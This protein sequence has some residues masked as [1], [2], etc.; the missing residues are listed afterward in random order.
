MN[1]LYTSSLRVYIAL[2]LLALLGIVAGLDLPISLYP[3][4]NRPTIQASIPYG[5]LNSTEFRETYGDII[6]QELK[7]IETPDLAVDKIVADYKQNTLYLKIEFGW[8]AEP[9]SAL[10]EVS[11]TLNS[12]SGSWPKIVRDGLWVDYWS[13]SGGF[14]AVSFYSNKRTLDELYDIL[15][16]ELSPKLIKVKDASEAGLWNPNQKM[17]QVELKPGAMASLGIFPRDVENAIYKGFEGYVGGSITLGPKHINIQMS[18]QVDN[19]EDLKS[20]LVQT[21]SG[22]AVT[23]DEVASLSIGPS[24]KSTR[25]F[26]TSGAKSLI[27]FANPRSGGNVKRMAEEVLE[28]VESSKKDFPPDIQYKV[29]VDPSEFIR[30]A[31][32][33]VFHEVLMAAG[34]AVLVL[35]LFIGSLKNT[36]TAAIEI[37][38][39]MVLAFILMKLTDMNINL[40]S[41][42]GLALSAGMNVDAS[43]VVMENIF[44]HL[45]EHEG[46][47]TY[48]DKVALIIRA[49][50]EVSLPIMGAT[51][52]SLVVFAPLAFTS[53]LTNAILGDLAKAVVF[54]HGFSAVVAIILVPTVRLHMMT[55]EKK[56]FIPTSP[57]EGTLKKMERLYERS[58]RNFLSR[59][60]LQYTV[61][62]LSVCALIGALTFIAPN[63]KREIIGTPDTDW[64]ILGVN[65]DGQTLIAQ[66]EAVT[67]RVEADLLQKF[68]ADIG[69][70]FTQIHNPNSSNIMGRLHNKKDMDRI[71]KAMQEH[72]QNTPELRFWVI[73]WN[74]AELPIPNPPD[75]TLEVRGGNDEDRALVA[76]SLEEE[77]SKLEYF[78]SLWS[79]PSATLDDIIAIRP[80]TDQWTQITKSG[81]HFVPYDLADL[82]RVA[83]EGKTLTNVTIAGDTMNVN[84][85]YPAGSLETREDIEALPVQV[86]GKLIPLGALA[87]V[88]NEKATPKVSRED[89]RELYKVIGR[90]NKGNESKAGPALEKTDAFLAKFK[91]EMK[92]KLELTSAPAVA[93]VDARKELSDALSQLATAIGLSILLIF[94]TLFFQ[95]GHL[96]HVAIVLTAIPSGILGVLI[97]LGV[98][99]STLSLNSALGIILL[100]GIAVA[101][102]IIMVDF[103]RVM[104]AKGHA[105][106]EAAIWASVKRLRPI[107][108]TSL[109]TILGMLP[110]ALGLGEGGKVLRPLGLSVAGGLWVSMLFTLYIVPALEYSF[111]KKFPPKRLTSP[112]GDEQSST[113]LASQTQEQLQ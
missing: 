35:F 47:L 61:Y 28:I 77:L 45:E 50:K 30:D 89:G 59:P 63:L 20:V 101:N 90:F 4:S 91:E 108:I 97:A 23:L 69:Y 96:I 44:R 54:S 10:R 82:S 111:Y 62:A 81:A 64:V 102:S 87:Q 12:L 6:E 7:S 57:I 3:N 84:M 83:T 72:F 56:I 98:F 93:R 13:E 76:K 75:M 26:K 43:V 14:I 106:K 99:Q 17:L 65:T 52:A 32:S 51:I 109:T 18:R 68:G 11:T 40:I 67:D 85:T 95:F 46:E 15:E 34:L 33:N 29:L 41:L 53:A 92:D 2:G 27:L 88:V 42:G 66:M 80:F 48:K 113:A 94:I 112:L 21:P 38:L 9:K 107:L 71:W 74:P 24:T 5:A 25:I 1:K 73:P 8:G 37:P 103:I 78:D 39:S 36:I 58:L 49:V 19:L 104:I 105:P 86:A 16:P 31:V 70:T 79:E 55:R 110:I 60:K 22:G 100:N